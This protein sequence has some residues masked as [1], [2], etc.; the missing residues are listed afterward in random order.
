MK[1]ANFYKRNENV[2]EENMF[3]TELLFELF[4]TNCA[5]RRTQ[6]TFQYVMSLMQT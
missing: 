5:G 4:Y 2:E 1:H 6:Y 3:T